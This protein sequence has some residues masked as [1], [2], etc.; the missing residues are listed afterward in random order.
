[1]IYG[2]WD[3]ERVRIFCQFGPFFTLLPPQQPRKLEIWKNGKQPWRYYHFKRVYNKWKSYDIWFLIYWA[4][5]TKVFVILDHFLLFDTF[6][7]PKNL[8]FE[9]MKREPIDIIILHKC[10][11]NDNN[12]MYSSWDMKCDR[13][14]FFVV[15]DRFLPFYPPSNP[16]KLKFCKTK[17]G[18]WR[19]HHFIKWT[20]NHDHMLHSSLDMARNGCN[21]SFSF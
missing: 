1:M 7:N 10:T 9:K 21:C 19:Y 20:K 16:I 14:T 17:K 2:S 12:M 15:L 4:R 18:N 8:N 6:K 5:K 3:A 13:Q 11:T